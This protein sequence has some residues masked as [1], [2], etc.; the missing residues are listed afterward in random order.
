VVIGNGGRSRVDVAD[1]R[2]LGGRRRQGDGEEE[3]CKARRIDGA[4]RWGERGNRQ[5]LADDDDVPPPPDPTSPQGEG[6]RGG[7]QRRHT[8]G[9]PS[10]QLHHHHHHHL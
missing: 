1:D 5:I 10:H 9:R 3:S 8:I 4:T 7:V 6:R 2:G